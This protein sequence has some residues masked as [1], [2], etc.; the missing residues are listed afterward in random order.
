MAIEGQRWDGSSRESHQVRLQRGVK[1]SLCPW[2]GQN[3]R[4][5]TTRGNTR[6]KTEY[7]LCDGW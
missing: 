2:D 3:R 5:S 6:I 1:T 4:K 7:G